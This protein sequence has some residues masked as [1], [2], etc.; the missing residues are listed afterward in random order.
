MPRVKRG[1]THT[2]KRNKLLARTKGYKWGRK[3]Q[4]KRAKE[5]VVKAGA[6]SYVDR[7]KKKRV[8]RGLWQIKISAFTKNYESSGYGGSHRGGIYDN[9]FRLYY[10]YGPW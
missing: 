10:C 3:N 7:R 5:A 4:I 8:N 9:L 6:H 2:K 1:V